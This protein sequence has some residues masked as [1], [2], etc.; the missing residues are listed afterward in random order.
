MLTFRAESKRKS[1]R[2]L[3]GAKI[4]ACNAGA[5][6]VPAMN[7]RAF[8]YKDSVPGLD[9]G[10]FRLSGKRGASRYATSH[11]ARGEKEPPSGKQHASTKNQV[12]WFVTIKKGL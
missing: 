5:A 12:P 9:P 8:A 1:P 7:A 4:S 10:W 2:R 11:P 6:P 3:C